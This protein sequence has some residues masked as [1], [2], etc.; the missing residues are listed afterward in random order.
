MP[1]LADLPQTWTY[2]DLQRLLPDPAAAKAGATP[3]A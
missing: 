2:A 3:S 1:V